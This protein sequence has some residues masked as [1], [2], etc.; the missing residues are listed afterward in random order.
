MTLFDAHRVMDEVELRLAQ[1]FPGT[2]ILIH[3]EPEG[4]RDCPAPS[5][6]P[7]EA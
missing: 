6:G 3:P 2:E 1:E 7:T 4:H 5:V